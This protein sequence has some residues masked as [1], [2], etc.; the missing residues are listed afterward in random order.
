IWV[1]MVDSITVAVLA[2]LLTGIMAAL[3]FGP[4]FAQAAGSFPTNPGV[5]MGFVNTWGAAA[6]MILPPVM[7]SL[8]DSSGTFL[9]A[10]YLLGGVAALASIG[11]LGLVSIAKK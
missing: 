9:S 5:S 11:S 10:F 2:I 8:V 7:G 4:I 1:G 3:P 6:V